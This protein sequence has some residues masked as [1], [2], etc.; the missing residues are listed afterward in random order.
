[1]EIRIFAPVMYRNRRFTAFLLTL[2][3]LVSSSSFSIGMH[4]CGGHLQDV[5]VISE[6]EPCPMERDLPAC[7]RAV[8]SS[9]CQDIS[10]VHDGDEF[11]DGALQSLVPIPTP[12]A[13]TAPVVITLIAP[14][15]HQAFRPVPP[16]SDPPLPGDIHIRFRT[17]LI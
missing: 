8:K 10:V 16:S 2:L 14:A 5:S 13:I 7:H 9:C 15:G 1:M 11:R 12:V 17:L 3:T 4:L 6:P